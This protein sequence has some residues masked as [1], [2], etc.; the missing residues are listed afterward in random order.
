M[1]RSILALTLAALTAQLVGCAHKEPKRP[2]LLPLAIVAYD[3]AWTGRIAD[4]GVSITGR[5]TITARPAEVFVVSRSTVLLNSPADG[6][7]YISLTVEPGECL[8]GG[9]RHAYRVSACVAP[10]GDRYA[11][12]FRLKGCGASER[13]RGTGT[14]R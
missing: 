13:S 2:S 1:K 8:A 4:R 9:V 10:D 7:R 3:G 12:E 11:C 5:P 6:D 14:S